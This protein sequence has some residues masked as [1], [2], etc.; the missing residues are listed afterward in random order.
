[1]TYPENEELIGLPPKVNDFCMTVCTVN[2]SGSATSNNVL[3]HALFHMGI[4]SSGKNIFP[5]NIK[6]LPTWFVIRVSE[7]GYLG[8]VPYDDILVAMNPETF[9]DDLTYLP[10]GG[11][12]FYA[13]HIRLPENPRP[14]LIFY[15]MPIRRLVK[16]AEVPRNLREY[17]ENMA[18]VGIVGE[19]LGISMG[20][21]I[22]AL[23]RHFG[24]KATALET[25]L[26]MVKTGYDWAAENIVKRDRYSV[27]P[28]P[29]MKDCILTDGNMPQH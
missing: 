25:N 20:S 17:M 5:S 26:K 11:V 7:K 29:S 28:L 21:I 13:D 9:L 15:P 27:K 24:N 18:Y 10:E 16:E 14:D 22:Y 23:K 1:M 2:G 19:V 6:G 3:Y 8:R 12:I 4:P